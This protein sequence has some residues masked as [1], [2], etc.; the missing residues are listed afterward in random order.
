M[1]KRNKRTFGTVRKLPSGRYQAR[2]T[3]PTGELKTAPETFTSKL[4][5]DSY[6]ASIRTDINRGKWINPN[7]GSLVL[8]SLEGYVIIY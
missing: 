5:A 4:E 8:R 2:F 7:A 6:L 1:N 3:T